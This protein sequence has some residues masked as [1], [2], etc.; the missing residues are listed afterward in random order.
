[1]SSDIYGHFGKS[2]KMGFFFRVIPFRWDRKNN[3]LIF[4]NGYSSKFS[5]SYKWCSEF[6][7]W[8]FVKCIYFL[9]QLCLLHGFIR[10]ADAPVSPDTYRHYAQQVLA[11][12]GFSI[13]CA[14]QIGITVLGGEVL[15]FTNQLLGFC[16]HIQGKL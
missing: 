11:F 16:E 12:V 8:D 13:P 4:A 7:G 15:L 3:L 10:I 1:M 14:F 6:T 2:V 5:K 9:Q